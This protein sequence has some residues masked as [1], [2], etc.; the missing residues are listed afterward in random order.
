VYRPLGHSVI[1][2]VRSNGNWT[3]AENGSPIWS[4]SY[5]QLWNQRLSRDGQRIAAVV[6][7][8]FGKWTVAVDDAPWNLE[9]DDLVLP[10]VFSA[11][12]RRVAATV[13]HRGAWSVA[14]D[15][16]MWP[17]SF[18]MVWDPVFSPSGEHV[19]AKVERDGRFAVARD[20]TV[21]SP[22]VDAL[23]QPTFDPTGDRVLLRT[24]EEGTYLRSVVPFDG[25][26]GT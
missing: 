8:G 15:G 24:V 20:G 7:Q 18:D 14:V 25:K 10:P 4:G 3:L 23:W 6:A 1:A 12:G 19:V 26:F 21:W 5:L 22:W 11:D 13:R 16:S 9:C 2:P 17:E